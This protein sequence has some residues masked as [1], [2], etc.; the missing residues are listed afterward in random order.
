MPNVKIVVIGDVDGHFRDVFQKLNTLHSKNSFA[1]GI[2]VGNLF[3]DPEG[4]TTED[5]QAIQ[6]LLDGKIGIQLPVYFAL[7]NHALPPRVIDRLRSSE[8]ELCANLFFLGR[9]STTKTSDGVRIVAL[10]GTFS[11]DSSPSSTVDEYLPSYTQQDAKILKGAKHADILITSDWPSA[12]RSNSKVAIGD[13]DEPISQEC[14]SELCEAL[15]PRYHFSAASP[16]LFYER[17]PFSHVPREDE[18]GLYHTTR[19]LSLA[20]YNN[21]S[22]SKWIYAF[23]LEPGAQPASSL[24]AGATASPFANINKK[25]SAL[26]DQTSYRFSSTGYD[27]YE[28]PRKRHRHREKAPPPTQGECYFCLSNPNLPTHLVTSIATEA[29]LTTAKGPLTTSKTFPSLPFPSHILVIPMAHAPTLSLIPEPESRETTK[30]EMTKYREGIQKM[31]AT[32]SKGELGAVTWEISRASGFHAHWQILPLPQSIISKGLV[33]VAFKV[34]AENKSHPHL[35]KG[36]PDEATDYFRL[37]IYD[38]EKKKEEQL[39]FPIDAGFRDLQYARRV[40]AKLLGLEGRV[41][42]QDCGQTL[43]EETADAEAFKEAFKAWDFTEEQ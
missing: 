40:C 5:D 14:V 6:E 13:H 2:V 22:K 19:F 23:S 18:S 39:H 4:S 34:E 32:V 24:P 25:R 3:A 37:W 29:Y 28:R 33:E 43:D 17:E 10:G 11:S 41:M 16:D 20:A 15:R 42:W 38:G 36:E 7:R 9:R 27:S 1:F 8:G 30:V 31:I 12:V 26:P 35:E 21:S